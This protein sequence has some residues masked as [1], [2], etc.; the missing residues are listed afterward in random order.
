MSTGA[1]VVFPA[2]GPARTVNADVTALENAGGRF[3]VTFSVNY[4]L[5]GKAVA[6]RLTETDGTSIL[7]LTDADPEIT[8]NGQTV[9][10]DIPES[11]VTY[12]ALAAGMYDYGLDVGAAGADADYRV[13]GRWQIADEAGLVTSIGSVETSVT[14]G[15]VTIIVEVVS[16]ATVNGIWGGISGT[17]SDQTDLQAELDARQLLSQKD[18]PSG[19]CGLDAGSKVLQTNISDV[20]NLDQLLDVDITGAQAGDLLVREASSQWVDAV[21][22][23]PLAGTIAMNSGSQVIALTATWQEFVPTAIVT[24]S[25][26]NVVVGTNNGRLRIDYTGT[27]GGVPP[28]GATFRGEL[29][30]YLS[31]DI[32]DSSA[33][34]DV[35]F[36]AGGTVFPEASFAHARVATA[37][38]HTA[39]L[40]FPVA[41]GLPIDGEAALTEFSVFLRGLVAVAP[42]VE[43]FVFELTGHIETD[44]FVPRIT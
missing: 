18:V 3:N 32:P 27:G 5:T 29:T 30:V 15:D 17:L 11:N 4:D 43:T 19:Y 35:S 2:T 6:Y 8:I 16:G 37:A 40:I 1:C 7:A 36:G 34:I 20:I 25:M 24:S 31:L 9:E 23:E 26:Q 42:Q 44:Q 13:Q 22:V 14:V 33:T 28:G 38:G 10:V 41:F 21:L 12:G 39:G